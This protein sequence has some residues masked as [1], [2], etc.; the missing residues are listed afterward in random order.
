MSSTATETTKVHALAVVTD[1]SPGKGL[2]PIADDS[3]GLMVTIGKKSVGR[4]DDSDC[5]DGARPGRGNGKSLLRICLAIGQPSLV[6]FAVSFTNGIIT[7]GLPAISRSINLPRELFLWP[8]SVYGLTS[9]AALLLAGS[10]AD[11]V[12]AK[13]VELV[14]VSIMATFA[15]AS[16]LAQTGQ[17]LVAFRALMGIG[18]AMHLP[19]SV[20]LVAAAVPR[21][22]ARNVG[23]ACLGLS[24]TFGFSLGLILAGVLLQS[25]DEGWRKAFFASGSLTAV[26]AMG[27]YWVLPTVEAAA[28]GDNIWLK[29]K[30]EVDWVGLGLSSA[31]LSLF[32]YVLAMLSAD[33]SAI[34]NGTTATLLALSLMLLVSFP[35]WMSYRTRHG[36]AALIP[37]SLWRNIPFASICL[38]VTLSWGAL[39]SIELF[40]S[41]YFQ[42]LQHHSSLTT[43]LLLLPMILAGS[44][45]NFSTGV[46][47]DRLPARWL[48]AM[49]SM[50]TAGSPLIMALVDP[51]LS[52][53]YLQFWAQVLAPLSADVLF[54]IGLIVV[55]ESFPEQTQALAGAVFNT[56]AQLG[57]SL[58]MGVCQVVAL[59]VSATGGGVRH[60]G[61][62][63]QD[64]VAPTDVAS[65]LR[66]YRA[67]FW[68]IFGYMLL[69]TAVAV[70]GLR[71][72]GRV[73]V[74]VGVNR[75]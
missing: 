61:S 57:L 31:G 20:S 4:I 35:F 9:G 50:L 70:V 68:A 5:V 37:N 72:V 66:G 24:T 47:V 42:E 33:L 55:S 19:S 40:S 27:G 48:V 46:F 12:G 54:T 75:D 44:L 13:S 28:T 6:N 22:R 62:G 34:R 3:S 14:G 23:F 36:K 64:A 60:G 2:N 29:L 58:G 41:L 63:S 52:Y 65:L 18:M 7:V 1:A 56:V 74:K 45:V 73:G 17:Q 67:S 25:S 38:L 53:W 21:G 51:N 15:L 8:H 10:I 43:S 69:C 30:A 26:A 32:S 39:N 59:G 11:L 49:S 71:N 16:G